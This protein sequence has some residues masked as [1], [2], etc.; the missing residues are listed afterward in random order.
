MSVGAADQE[1][2]AEA[3][4]VEVAKVVAGPLNEQVT[5][6]GTLPSDEAVTISSEIP[7]RLEAIHF[8]EGQPKAGTKTSDGELHPRRLAV[9]RG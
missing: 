1:S 5:A 7:R 9:M 2:E 6:V 4:R 3:V 8:E